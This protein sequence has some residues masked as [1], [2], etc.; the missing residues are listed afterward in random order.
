MWN[1]KRFRKNSNFIDIGNFEV[2]IY[3]R[4]WHVYEIG[5]IAIHDESPLTSSGCAGRFGTWPLRYTPF[6]DIFNSVHSHFG[7]CPSR[8]IVTS[9]PGHVISGHV[10]SGQARFGTAQPYYFK[11]L[12]T[13]RAGARKLFEIE[14]LQWVDHCNFLT[15]NGHGFAY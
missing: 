5:L 15:D 6:R 2:G 10:I 7:T 13:D 14:R 3:F 4:D 8:I 12:C 1:L 9:G 11:L